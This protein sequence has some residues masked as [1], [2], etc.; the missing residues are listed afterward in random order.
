VGA[1]LPPGAGV[2]LARGILFF[3]GSGVSA[4]A[5]ILAAWAALGA[6]LTFRR[7]RRPHAASERIAIRPQPEP[8]FAAAGAGEIA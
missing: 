5:L 4:P 2:D 3:G 7:L 1:L 6:A 8:S